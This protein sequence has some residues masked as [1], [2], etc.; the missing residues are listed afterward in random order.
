MKIKDEQILF[1]NA[2][3]EDLRH[4]L[5]V[6]GRSQT[7]S[8]LAERVMQKK[9]RADRGLNLPLKVSD[10]LKTEAR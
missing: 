3:L 7:T 8:T 6:G 1:L 2:K 9:I 5:E 10:K 4:Y